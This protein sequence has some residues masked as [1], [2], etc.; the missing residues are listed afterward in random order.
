MRNGMRKGSRNEGK[1]EDKK[2]IGEWRERGVI[3]D[4]RRKERIGAKGVGIR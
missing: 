2:E 3:S 1:G 4:G